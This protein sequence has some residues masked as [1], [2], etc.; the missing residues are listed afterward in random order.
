MGW[1]ACAGRALVCTWLFDT[2]VCMACVHMAVRYT[3]VLFDTLV[4][5]H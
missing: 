5:I 4:S 2:L 1:F 3:G